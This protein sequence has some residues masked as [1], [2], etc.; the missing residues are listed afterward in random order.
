MSLGHVSMR[1]RVFLLGGKVEIDS[2]RGYGTTIRAWVPLKEER[3]EPSARA[4]GWT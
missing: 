1:Q 2:K 3:G 4:V